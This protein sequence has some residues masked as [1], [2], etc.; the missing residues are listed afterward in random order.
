M[1]KLLVMSC[2]LIA[3]ALIGPAHARS[4]NRLFPRLQQGLANTVGVVRN[5]VGAAGHVAGNVVGTTRHVVRNTVGT[6]GYVAGNVIGTAAHIVDYSVGVYCQIQID[7]YF[8]ELEGASLLGT[9]TRAINQCWADGFYR[10]DCR[11]LVM[12]QSI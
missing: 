4:N 11:S 5:V 7:H 10:D 2:L 1:K 8:L 6:V 9:Q 3:T 12:C